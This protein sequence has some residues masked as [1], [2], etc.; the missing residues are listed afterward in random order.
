MYSFRKYLDEH[1]F[2]SMKAKEQA[3][4]LHSFDQ[5][6]SL[7]DDSKLKANVSKMSNLQKIQIW[8]RD[9]L[10]AHSPASTWEVS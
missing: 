1:I 3:K 9:I 2:R 4:Q 6:D 5:R 8:T 10:M 7:I